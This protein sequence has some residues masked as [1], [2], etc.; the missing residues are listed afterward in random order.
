VVRTL[1]GFHGFRMGKRLGSTL[2]PQTNPSP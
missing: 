2:T 1:N